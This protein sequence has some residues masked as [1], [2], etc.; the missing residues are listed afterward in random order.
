MYDFAD[1]GLIEFSERKI[2]DLVRKN[3]HCYFF[4]VDAEF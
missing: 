3:E 1:E 2:E 4:L